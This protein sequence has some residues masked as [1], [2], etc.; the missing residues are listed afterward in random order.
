M[1]LLG[2]FLV[3]MSATS[4]T[5]KAAQNAVTRTAGNCAQTLV[6]VNRVVASSA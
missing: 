2:V 6:D 4:Q 5:E 1:I 3:I